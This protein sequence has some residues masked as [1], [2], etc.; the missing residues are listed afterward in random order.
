MDI[1]AFPWPLTLGPLVGFAPDS[2]HHCVCSDCNVVSPVSYGF[3]SDILGIIVERVAG[4]SL[5]DFW[6]VCESQRVGV[7]LTIPSL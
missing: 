3:S 2:L 1:L 7:P 5:A 4:Q 6:S